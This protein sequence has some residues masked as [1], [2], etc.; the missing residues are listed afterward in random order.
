[1]SSMTCFLR[2][3]TVS[4]WFQSPTMGSKIPQWG[5][6]F[7]HTGTKSPC[8]KQR[9]T[10]AMPTSA[11]RQSQ[12][13]ASQRTKTPRNSTKHDRPSCTKHEVDTHIV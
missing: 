5:Q 1:M 10:V 6:V 12:R 13:A 9:L 4:V 2:E 7:N 3:P 11:P 8:S